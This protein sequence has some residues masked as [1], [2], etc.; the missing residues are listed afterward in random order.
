MQSKVNVSQ[1]G[2][3]LCVALVLAYQVLPAQQQP[4]AAQRNERFLARSV[5]Q[6]TLM[7][8]RYGLTTRQLAMVTAI[9]HTFYTEVG[10]LMETEKNPSLGREKIRKLEENRDGKLKETFTPRQYA[11]YREDMEAMALRVKATRQESP[12]GNDPF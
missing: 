7:Q 8:E 1:M 10:A 12:S 4:P 3:L 6:T 11:R 5:Q 2:R 9:N